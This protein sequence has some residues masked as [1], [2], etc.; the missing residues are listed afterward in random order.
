ML[1]GLSQRFTKAVE[2]NQN[3]YG[4]PLVVITYKELYGWTM[5][6]IVSAVGAKNNCT[7]C[8]V[9]RR[10]ALDRSCY[11]WNDLFLFLCLVPSVFFCYD[12]HDPIN[13]FL[14]MSIIHC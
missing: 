10:R 2:R 7:F 9:F 4:L 11:F 13:G 8:G 12:P 5:D 14:S 1:L 6:E 3:D